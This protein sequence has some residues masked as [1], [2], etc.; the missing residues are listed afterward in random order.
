M[1]CKKWWL[2]IAA[3]ITAAVIAGAVFFCAGGR[4]QSPGA[5][6]VKAEEE[7]FIYE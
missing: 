6:L 2:W 4:E 7:V 1:T 5:T 3:A